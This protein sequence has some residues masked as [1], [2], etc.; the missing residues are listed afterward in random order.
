MRFVP[1]S[2]I[3]GRV[4]TVF[5]RAFESVLLSRVV[6][7]AWLT[8]VT[9]FHHIIPGHIAME[10]N[11]ALLCASF[12]VLL[13]STD[14]ISRVTATIESSATTVQVLFRSQKRRRSDC[15]LLWRVPK[16][17]PRLTP[18]SFSPTQHEIGSCRCCTPIISSN[19]RGTRP[20]TLPS[21]EE[22][23]TPL[24]PRACPGACCPPCP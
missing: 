4:N 1:T 6:T 24:L 19:P 17:L 18:P 21:C 7:H 15:S 5:D 12:S 20:P 22:T 2:L 16:L 13:Q 10:K 3:D 14:P 23:P 8:A 11:T 9:N